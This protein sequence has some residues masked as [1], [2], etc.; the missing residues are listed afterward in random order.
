[1]F[2]KQLKK[3]IK[4]KLIKNLNIS[5]GVRIYLLF[6]NRFSAFYQIAF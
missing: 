6:I 4:R 2:L 3:F 5:F 1:M